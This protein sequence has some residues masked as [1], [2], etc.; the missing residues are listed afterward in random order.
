M[1]L[2]DSQNHP[3][4]QLLAGIY[5]DLRSESKPNPIAGPT[6]KLGTGLHWGTSGP[7]S[8]YCGL[9]SRIAQAIANRKENKG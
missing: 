3:S 6:T 1:S 8:T 4:L 2:Q 7:R 5:G 9:T